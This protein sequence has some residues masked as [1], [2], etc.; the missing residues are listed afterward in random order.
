MSATDGRRPFEPAEEEALLR[1]LRIKRTWCA[2]VVLGAAAAALTPFM[3]RNNRP[4]FADATRFPG[5][6]IGKKGFRAFG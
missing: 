4:C 2:F 5:C 1:E 6:S 3:T